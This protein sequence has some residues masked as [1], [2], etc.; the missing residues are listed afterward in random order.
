MY[1]KELKTGAQKCMYTNTHSY[2]QVHS[3]I[4]YNSPN[5]RTTQISKNIQIDKLLY[6]YTMEYH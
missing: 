6:L 3:N 5:V 4:S 2:T 1:P